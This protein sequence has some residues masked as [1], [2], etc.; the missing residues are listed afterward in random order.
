MQRLLFIAAHPDDETFIAGGTMAKC[1]SEGGMV[2][3][4]CAT[5]GER[6]RTAGLVP[7]AELPPIREHELRNA[8]SILGY[9][10]KEL[11]EAPVDE[12][13][14]ELVALIRASRPEVVITFDRMGA[15]STRTMS[16]SAA[17]LRT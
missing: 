6:G 9:T 2:T 4:A 5:R 1:V 14:R 3:L 15:T 13:R 17:S 8:M 16:R 11:A 10:D 12:M 7:E